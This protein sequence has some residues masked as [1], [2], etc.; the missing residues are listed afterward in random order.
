[1]N[2][3]A[4]TPRTLVENLELL[5]IRESPTNPRKTFKQA[6]LEELAADIK[7][8]GVLQPVMVRPAP[9]GEGHELI[10]G[11]KRFRAS[12]LAG[13]EAIPAI[14]RAMTDAEVLETQLVENAKR[15]D[16]EPLEEAEA[17]EALHKKH[18]YSVEDLAAKL[19]KSIGTVYARLKLCALVP[20]AR[21]ALAEGKITPSTALLVARVPPQLQLEAVKELEPC[22]GRRYH[23]ADVDN[24]EDPLG[25]REAARIIQDRF[26][27]RL[28]DAPFDKG[29]PELVVRAGPCTTCPKRTGNQPELFADVKSKDTCTDPSCF[30]QKR[31]AH[32]IELR[33]K[34]EKSGQRVLSDKEAKKV[35]TYGDRVAYGSNF[36]DLDEKEYVGGK[37]KTYRQ[38]LGKGA[39]V[40]VV[41]ARTEEGTIKELVAKSAVEKALKE[42][43]KKPP[44]TLG[45][46][47]HRRELS[48]AE[49]AKREK[50][51][52]RRAAIGEAIGEVVAET[53][54]RAPSK[55]FWQVLAA[56]FLGGSWHDTI[57]DVVARRGIDRAASG[58]K[59]R[60]E[61]ILEEQLETMS[62]GQ[63]RG[64]V[65]ELAITKGVY[66]QL[67]FDRNTA[68]DAKRPFRRA[69]D[70]YKVDLKALEAK[71]KSA[72]KTAKKAGK[73]KG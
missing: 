16:I 62:E 33:R 37:Q 50:A 61:D 65:L 28:A 70:L 58:V 17:F 47:A 45:G 21:K 30:K 29:D 20:G 53:E 51:L 19:G 35:F 66:F 72:N 57:S 54:K 9:D 71:S 24:G 63:L 38:L 67:D 22:G 55:A 68:N 42:S 6:E 31:D 36:V 13:V 8:R 44:S 52:V 43:G 7:K 18:G 4:E 48:D 56:A 49:K 34:A 23:D 2:A 15:S 32:W 27:L 1:M 14:V 25:A 11:A 39:D 46:S 60:G 3:V 26:M 10:F 12:S 69:C 40:P 41:L 64:L 59:K 5:T 73:R